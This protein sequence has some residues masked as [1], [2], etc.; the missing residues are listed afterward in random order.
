MARTQSERYPEIRENI[1][2]NAARLFAEQGYAG[3]TIIDLAEACESSRGAL[4]H[5]FGS[6]EDIL[7]HILDEHVRH[8]FEQIQTAVQLKKAPLEQCRAVIETMVTVNSASQSEQVVLL[9]ELGELSEEQQ[10]GIVAVQRQ[11]TET[12]GDIL[13]RIDSQHRLTT[14]T[15]KVYAMMLFGIINYTFAWYDPKGPV[16]PEEYADMTS[17]L[18]IRGFTGS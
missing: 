8:L 9:N 6:K 12:V 13:I 2:K 17:D 11:M 18:F 14:R 16:G 3:T 5:Y 4:Y 10:R 15:K 7:F 1:L